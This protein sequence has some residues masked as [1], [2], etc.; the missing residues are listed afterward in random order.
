[1]E[2]KNMIEGNKMEVKVESSEPCE[3]TAPP[4]T[5]REEVTGQDEAT[6]TPTPTNHVRTHPARSNKASSTP[7]SAVSISRLAY[8]LRFM[9]GK[10]V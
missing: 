1:M 8:N 10:L 7:V 2:E 5:T 9:I 6:A 4:V 3:S